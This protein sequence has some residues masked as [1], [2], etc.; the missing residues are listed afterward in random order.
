MSHQHLV[1]IIDYENLAA[2]KMSIFFFVVKNIV[3]AE[4]HLF[5]TFHHTKCV[6]SVKS[7]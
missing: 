6:A 7:V 4:T 3:S 2:Q 5:S 1:Y